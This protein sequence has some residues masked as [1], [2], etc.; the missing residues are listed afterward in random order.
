MTAKVMGC[1]VQTFTSFV[2]FWLSHKIVGKFLSL[3]DHNW[4]FLLSEFRR[5]GGIADNVCQKEGK[6]G[7]GIFS[8]NPTLRAKI[9]TP[10][11]LLIKKDDIYL[12]D[13]KLRIKKD[14]EYNEEIR[15]FFNFYQ[16]NFSWGSGGKETTE[17]FE[18]GLSLFNSNLKDLIKKYALV[19]LEERHKGKWDNVIKNQFLN[20]RGIQFGNSS[21]IAPIWELVNH[22]VRSFPFIFNEE[23]ISTPN[24]PASNREIRHSYSNLSPLNR[25]FSY[26]FFSEE[27]I[28]FSIPF[29]ITIENLGINIFCKGIGLNNDSMKIE[30]SGNKIILEGL[31]IADVNH[32]RLPYDYF[33]EILTKIGHINIP[34]DLLLKIFQLNISVRKKIIDQSHLIENEVFKTLT[35]LMLYEIN[36]IPS[37]D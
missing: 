34:K 30:R 18:K 10:S 22:K 4:D 17:L 5:L 11:K 24:Y 20:A 32:P 36:L 21:V 33:D 35:K 14:K 15:N 25:F 8:V 6:N 19:D 27:T 23:G 26:G 2:I 29:S 9:F 31:P 7:R 1:F 37:H 16:D 13:N 3:M 12:E 28:V